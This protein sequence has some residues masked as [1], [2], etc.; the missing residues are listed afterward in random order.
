MIP[1]IIHQVWLG[2]PMPDEL[3]EMRQSLIDAH[4][5]WEFR[6]WGDDDFGWLRN[7]DLFDQAE[8]IAPGSEGQFRSDVARY[9][10]LARYGGV[11]VDCDIEAVPGRSL[12]EL[13]DL[14]A[15]LRADAGPIEAFAGYECDRW[16][17]NAVIGS[18]AGGL[19]VEACV[20]ALPARVELAKGKGWRPNRIS[21]P[22]LVTPIARRLGVTLFAAEVF[23]PYRFDELHRGGDAVPA[24]TVL[25]HHWW[26]QR[27]RQEVPL[28]R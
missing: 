9:E 18:V 26:N 7:Q 27:T 1:K 22:H 28:V 12:D 24:G 20:Q 15:R 6:L 17:N 14:A 5:G 19:F 2:G 10:I 23:Y 4:P 21:G 8:T 11:Y 13:L 25:R 3:V 16:V